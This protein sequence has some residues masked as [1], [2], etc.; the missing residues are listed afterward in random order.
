MAPDSKAKIEIDNIV[1][2]KVSK[3]KFLGSIV[4]D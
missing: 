3:F 2:P 1:Y 4:P